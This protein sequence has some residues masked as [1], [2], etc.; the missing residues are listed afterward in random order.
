MCEASEHDADHSEA[1][2]GCDGSG[3]ALEI[4]HQAT[5]ATDPGESPLHDPALG[6]HDEAMEVGTFDDLDL[7]TSRRSDGLRHFWSLI[8]AIG[9]NPLDEGKAPPRPA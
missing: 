7:P 1:D 5:T 8:A 6:Q 2:K 9:E 4:A 3:V